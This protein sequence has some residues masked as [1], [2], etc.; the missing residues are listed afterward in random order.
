MK[1]KLLTLPSAYVILISL[2]LM[3]C[4]KEG[5]A[6]PAGPQ[7]TA[8]PA[9]PTGPTGATGPAGTANVIYSEWLDVTY[10]ADVDGTDTSWSATIAAPQLTDSIISQGVVKVYLNLGSADEPAIVAL[11][12]DAAV[13]GAVISPIFEIGSITILSSDNFSTFTE[14]NVKFLQYRYVLIPGGTAA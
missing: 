14:D 13:F 4:E 7:G 3:S 2:F 12:L 8:G 11:P 1:F 6:G 9:G 5:P 10:D